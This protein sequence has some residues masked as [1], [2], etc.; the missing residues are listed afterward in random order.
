MGFYNIYR[1]DSKPDEEFYL[2]KSSKVTSNIDELGFKV[3]KDELGFEIID[4]SSVEFARKPD[5]STIDYL[6]KK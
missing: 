3:E 1:R 4:E 6:V 5:T 2:L